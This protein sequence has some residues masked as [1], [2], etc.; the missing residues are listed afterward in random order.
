MISIVI[1]VVVVVILTNV[2]I[3]GDGIINVFVSVSV[4]VIDVLD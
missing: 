3:I 4:S 1:I 2:A